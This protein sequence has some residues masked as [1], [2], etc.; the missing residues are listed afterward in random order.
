MYNDNCPPNCALCM[1]EDL[2]IDDDEENL[3]S[4]YDDDMEDINIDMIE[5]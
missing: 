2:Y 5:D 3:T 1:E 4:F